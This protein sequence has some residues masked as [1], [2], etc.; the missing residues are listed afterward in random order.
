MVIDKHRENRY[1]CDRMKK[2]TP[3]GIIPAR[4]ILKGKKP[5]SVPVPL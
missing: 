3:P 2:E 5:H 4:L 1:P